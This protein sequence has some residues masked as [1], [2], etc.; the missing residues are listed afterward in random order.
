M[1]CF[2][3]LTGSRA[4]F[5]IRA[6][7]GGPVIE[8]F[9]ICLANFNPLLPTPGTSLYKRLESE[10]RLLYKHWWLDHKYRYGSATFKP[11]LMSP[12]DLTNG[13]FKARK[14]FNSYS[15]IF[16]RTSNLKANSNSIRNLACYI[17][18]NLINKKEIMA[19][20]GSRLGAQYPV[21]SL[22]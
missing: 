9:G 8:R 19:K 12:D 2:L 4:F 1:P 14:D 11:A 3:T 5:R 20:Q 21:V 6:F 13:C 7:G 16:L 15:S 17:F 22:E 10:G 18:A